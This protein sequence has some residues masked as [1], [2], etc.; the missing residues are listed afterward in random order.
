MLAAA[1]ADAAAVGG[2]MRLRGGAPKTGKAP[3]RADWI[4]KCESMPVAEGAPCLVLLRLRAESSPV[5]VRRRIAG[6]RLGADTG[7]PRSPACWRRGAALRAGD[8]LLGGLK[9]MGLAIA[10]QQEMQEAAKKKKK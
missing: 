6:P 3:T 5:P 1:T 2:P 4:K 7:A 8:F 10:K 9:G